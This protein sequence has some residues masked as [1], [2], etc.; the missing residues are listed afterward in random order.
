MLSNPTRQDLLQMI[1][2]ARANLR[3]AEAAIGGPS[4]AEPDREFVT[5][6]LGNAREAANRAESAFRVYGAG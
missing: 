2:T 5:R 3:L 1:V 4:V 6:L